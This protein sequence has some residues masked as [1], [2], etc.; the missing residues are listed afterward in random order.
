MHHINSSEKPR[1]TFEHDYTAL[2]IE[3]YLME[4]KSAIYRHLQ[5]HLT[6]TH[7]VYH[8]KTTTTKKRMHAIA[9]Y[10]KKLLKTTFFTENKLNNN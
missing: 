3:S 2:G 7:L 9:V 6:P 5:C 1:N 8:K 4:V 10:V